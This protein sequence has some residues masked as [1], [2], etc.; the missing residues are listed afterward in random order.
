MTSI[1]CRTFKRSV[2]CSRKQKDKILEASFCAT[3][4]HEGGFF[5]ASYHLRVKNDTQ[6]SGKKVSAKSHVDYIFRED[7]KAHADYINR[8]GAQKDRTDCVFKGSQLPKWAKGSAQKFFSAAT[9]YEDKGN[10]RYKEIELSLPNELTLEQ[11]REIVGRFIK[12]HLANHYYAYAIHEKAGE[13]SGERHPHVHIMFSERLIDD[14]ERIK[15]RPACKYFRRAARPLKGEQ[16]A[17]FER[18]R[19]HGAPKAPKWHDKKYLCEMRADYA[20]IQNEVLSANGYSIRVDHRTLK[21]QEQEAERNGDFFLSKVCKRTPEEYIGIVSAHKEEGLAAGVRSYRERVQSKQTVLFQADVKQKLEQEFEIKEMIRRA[22][23]ETF[24]LLKSE[25]YKKANLESEPLRNLNE[26]ILSGLARINRRKKDLVSVSNAI[27]RAQSEYLTE[28]ERKLFLDYK[29]RVGERHNL[30]MLLEELQALNES[31]PNQQQ[32][33]RE[34]ES[35]I[36]RKI[37]EL[38]DLFFQLRPELRAIEEKLQSSYRRKNVE[39]VAHG[40]LQANLVIW[41]ELRKTSEELLRNVAVLRGQI[42]VREVPKTTFTAKEIRDNLYRQ[43]RSLKAE[44]ERATENRNRLRFKIIS[45]KRAMVIAKNVFVQ[46]AFKKLRVEQYA[47][48]KAKSKYEREMLENRNREMFFNNT[49]WTNI[50]EKVQEQYYLTKEKIRLETTRQKLAQTQ[51]YLDSES[52][53]LETLCQTEEAQEKIVLIAAGVLRKNLKV[54]H[55]YEESKK[56]VS[57]LWQKTQE[58]KKRFQTLD[59]GY[60]RL[61]K[62]REYRVIRSASDSAKTSTLQEDELVKIIADA[63]LGEKYAV[64]L[65]ARSTGNNLEMEKDW[66]LM[67]EL[68]KDAFI[69]KRM[70]REL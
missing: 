59:N 39:L 36:Q 16:V 41:R 61:K 54:A 18:R 50:G 37:I 60:S 42:G 7:G 46:G 58:T 44:Y 34:I 22:E 52:V 69:Q 63:L 11:N 31:K 65:V 51:S 13:L 33:F 35:G 32:V 27:E 8:E 14:V 53:R 57:D 56:R 9:R 1:A 6:P 24:V 29:S 43:Y 68:D 64:A 67:S 66:E 45:P 19:E 55:E 26:V 17:S 47:Y 40:K 2:F 20:R 5:M 3:M 30:V 25:G 10:R 23:L 62:N 28:S 12:N 21:A 4:W 70:V 15:E 38:D 49:N 48:K